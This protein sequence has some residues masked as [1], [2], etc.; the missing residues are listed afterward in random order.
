V[1]QLLEDKNKQE[2]VEEADP[3]A[4]ILADVVKAKKGD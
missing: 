2:Q 3:I 4:K 1:E